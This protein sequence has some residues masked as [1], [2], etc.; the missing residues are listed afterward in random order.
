[1]ADLQ[2]QF[3]SSAD[4]EVEERH[5]LDFPVFVRPRQDAHGLAWFEANGEA[6]VGDGVQGVED[7]A[8]AESGRELEECFNDGE[9]GA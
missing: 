4:G 9:L 1:M 7:G 6:V 2:S 8:T 5:C 3:A